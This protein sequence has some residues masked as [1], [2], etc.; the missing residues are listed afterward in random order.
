MSNKPKAFKRKLKPQLTA[1]Q[2]KAHDIP[3]SLRFDRETINKYGN[4]N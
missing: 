3:R 2:R 4:E 1:E